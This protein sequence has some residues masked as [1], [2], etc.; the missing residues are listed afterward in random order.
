MITSKQFRSITSILIPFIAFSILENTPVSAREPNLSPRISIESVRHKRVLGAGSVQKLPAGLS[1]VDWHQIEQE[2]QRNRHGMFADGP[3]YQARNFRQQWL[4]RFDGQGFTVTPD[5]KE[6]TWGLQLRSYGHTGKKIALNAPAKMRTDKNRIVYQR[7]VVEEWYINDNKGLEQGFTIQKSPAG[8]GELRL[9]LEIRGGLKAKVEVGGTQ[10][11]FAKAEVDV[12]RFGALRAWDAEG[13]KLNTRFEADGGNIQLVVQD[14]EARYPITIDPIAQQAYLKASN[15]GSSDFFGNAVA[16]SGDTLVVS[17]PGEASNA[18]G[19]NGSQSDNS[20]LGSGAA[21]VF[22][23]SGTTWSQQAYLKASNPGSGD[24]FGFFLAISGDTIVVAAANEDSASTGVNGNQND[25]NAINSG[26]AYVFTRTGTTWSQ[27]AY[28]KAS[29]TGAGDNF[30]DTISISGDTVVVGANGEASFATGV[31]GNQNDNS[32]TSAGAVYVFT[33]SGIVWSQQAYIK[34]SNTKAGQNFGWS[35]AISGDTLVVGAVNEQSNAVGVNGNQNDISTLGAGAAYVFT[36]SGTV[37]SQQAYLKASNSGSND[38]FGNAAAISGDTLVVGAIG[39][40][41][42]STGVN[43]VQTDNSA[44]NSGAVYV[45]TR[46]GTTWS[47]QAY[48]KA[49]NTGSGDFLGTS[50][51]ISGDTLIAGANGEASNATGVNGVQ[52]DNSA[53]NAGAVYVFTRTGT[54]WSQQAY[55]KASNAETRDDFGIAVAI[56]G[57]TLVVGAYGES[58][59]AVGVNGIQSDNT[60]VSS[61]ASYVFTTVAPPAVPSMDVTAPI[62]GSGLSNTFVLKYSLSTGYQNLGVVNMLMNQYLNGDRACYIAYSQPSQVLYLVN[63]LGPGSGLSAGLT[64]GGSG[65]VSNGQCTVFAAGSSA[66]GVGTTLT[67]TLNMTFKAGFA[68]NQVIYLA[69]RDVNEANSGWVTKGFWS[70]PG[71]TTVFPN[72][73]AVTPATGS[74]A[75]TVI[76][77]AYDDQTNA[78]NLQTVWALINTAIDGRQACYV[79][80]Y[81]PGNQLYLYPDNGDGSQATNIVLTGTNSIPNGQCLISASGSSVTKVN[82]RLTLTLNLQFKSLF[83]GS[84]GIWTAAQTLGL[85]TSAWKVLGAWQVP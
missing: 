31:N 81:V 54:T 36:R 24:Y 39:E 48:I 82:G 70:V 34:A 16:I 27:Q 33:R 71:A 35:V 57:D 9:E 74:T 32:A 6:W 55:L 20:L 49:S 11:S 10:V 30:G 23:R 42:N 21:Y 25:E 4:T 28:L 85:V 75:S 44:V 79:A 67:L 56:S 66:A 61:G 73:V 29:N 60:A 83:A 53:S 84:K 7:G 63:D 12:L 43:G 14:T 17:A 37:W 64:L 68:G 26:A 51:A 69:G 78:T 40:A 18:T 77:Y 50:V 58:S 15:T 72:P 19:V 13:R 41:S 2:Y 76:S 1:V 62:A 45:F 5:H 22:T 52:T 47:Q 46:T 65:S 59:S 8:S 3:G 38:F 80:Y